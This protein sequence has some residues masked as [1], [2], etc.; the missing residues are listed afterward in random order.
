MLFFSRVN[1]NFCS[2]HIILGQYLGFTFI[3]LASLPGLLGGL[4]VPK[5]WIGLLGFLPIIIGIKQLLDDDN[6]DEVQTVNDE[7]TPEEKGSRW[8]K[9]FSNIPPQTFH[10]AA[11]TVANGGDNIGIYIPLFAST[12][13]IGFALTVGVFY[14][15]V[16]VWCLTAYWLTQHQ[17]I[18]SILGKYGNKITPWVLIIIGIHIL[19]DSESYRLL[20]IFR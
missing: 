18:A 1:P 9:I 12:D 5:T 8:R 7:I 2:R 3:I 15:M 20:E 11:V 13:L 17:K 19:L 16:G 14:V 6:S 10:V 4:V